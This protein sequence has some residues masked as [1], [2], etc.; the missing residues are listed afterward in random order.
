MRLQQVAESIKVANLAEQCSERH[1]T[2]PN[3]YTVHN[4]T[5]YRHNLCAKKWWEGEDKEDRNRNDPS[6]GQV[7]DL[8]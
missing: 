8:F 4:T 6:P 3:P 5:K 7:S 2:E 1:D